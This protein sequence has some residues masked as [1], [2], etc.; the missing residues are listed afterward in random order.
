MTAQDLPSA[1]PDLA[2]LRD[3]RD[4]LA[5]AA[6]DCDRDP[7][8]ITLVCVSKTFPAEAIEPV[9][10]CRFRK[11]DYRALIR[12]TPA[13]EAALLDRANH[14]LAAA[15]NQME[16]AARFTMSEA[17]RSRGA[18]RS[19]G[20]LLVRKIA[21][22]IKARARVPLGMGLRA[23]KRKP[24][25]PE[26]RTACQRRSLLHGTTM[27]APEMKTLNPQWAVLSDNKSAAKSHG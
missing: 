5:R 9:T 27:A 19:K 23:S 22:A 10:A 11:S 25:Q 3:V 2:G 1:S 12:E 8:G 21:M 6:D 24:T 15:Q 7:A 20:L 26:N 13:L 4:R 16:A 14:E 18:E 17:R